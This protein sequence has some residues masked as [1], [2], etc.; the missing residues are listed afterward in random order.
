LQGQTFTSPV[1]K[2]L[3]LMKVKLYTWR[4]T[5]PEM[6]L[7]GRLAGCM[8]MATSHDIEALIGAAMKFQFP[9]SGRDDCSAA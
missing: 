6:H 9:F 4:K 5:N 2:F 3:K 8:L 7:K 1:E